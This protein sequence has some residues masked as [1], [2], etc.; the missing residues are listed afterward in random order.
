MIKS[1]SHNP[2]HNL[3]FKSI[4]LGTRLCSAKTKAKLICEIRE[5]DGGE[6]REGGGCFW[7]GLGILITGKQHAGTS[8]AEGAGHRLSC[9]SLWL[10]QINEG[11]GRLVGWVGL[12][13]Y[14]AISAISAGV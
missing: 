14:N 4:C 5:L 8:R 2:V 10:V 1:C 13:D 11:G 3:T 12:W 6:L 9:G 7:D